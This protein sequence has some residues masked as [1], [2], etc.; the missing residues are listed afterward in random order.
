VTRS[1]ATGTANYPDIVLDNPN[2]WNVG[3]K[4]KVTQNIVSTADGV[5]V[6]TSAG[7]NSKLAPAIALATTNTLTAAPT[8]A[9]T[10]AEAY[11]RPGN[12]YGVVLASADQ[13]MVNLSEF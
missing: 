7:A 10:G 5:T 13:H 8:A 9:Y 4:S 2:G 11:G 6:V 12:Q 3:V 1:R